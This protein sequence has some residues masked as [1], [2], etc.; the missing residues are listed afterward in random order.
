MD[1]QHSTRHKILDLL[2]SG[3]VLASAICAIHCLAL[4]VLFILSPALSGFLHHPIVHLAMFFVVLP[5][6]VITLGFS[7]IRSGKT[8]FLLLGL[9]G[10]ALLIL[11]LLLEDH[12]DV[13]FDSVSTWTNILGGI[14]L[15]SAHILNIQYR[16]KHITC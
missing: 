6:A 11:G 1:C 2:D 9:L 3:G 15:S 14:F 13:G 7:V 5:L 12:H 16:K 4:P 8:L 10:C